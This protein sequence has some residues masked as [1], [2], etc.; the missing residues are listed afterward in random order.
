MRPPAEA[1]RRVLES[2]RE[3][4]RRF[5]TGTANRFAAEEAEHRRRLAGG[6]AP[7]AVILTCSDSR[8]PPTLVFDQG[9]GDLF[10]IRVA[11]NIVTREVLGSVEF[12]VGSLETRL[13]IVLGHTGC[14][15]VGAAV[16]VVRGDGESLSAN[17]RSITDPIRPA[18]SAALAEVVG[19][20]HPDAG[21]EL[22]DE[23]RA[24]VVERATR[25]NVRTSVRA[26]TEGSE[27]LRR[28]AESGELT[29]LGG[30]YCLEDGTVDF[31]D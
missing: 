4:N 30:E 31:F 23:R 9:L 16:D 11:G 3:G 27:L 10:V 18:V 6:Q 5:A 19:D 15:A 24:E 21:R 29:I 7:G 8:V 26:L 20:E 28:L 12:A 25:R 14:G 22:T 1:T 17:L 2:L 13:V